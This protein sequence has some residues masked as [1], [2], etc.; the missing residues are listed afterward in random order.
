MHTFMKHHHNED[1]TYSSLSKI[2]FCPFVIPLSH[3]LLCHVLT[4]LSHQGSALYFYLLVCLLDFPGGTDGKVS[5]YSVGDPGL[6]LGLGRFLGEKE[7]IQC[8]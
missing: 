3:L 2:S 4:F 5:V 8:D 1:R 6:I 7:I